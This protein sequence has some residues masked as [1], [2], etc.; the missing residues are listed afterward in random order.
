MSI[1]N[2]IARICYTRPKH[3][4]IVFIIIT[5]ISISLAV[6]IK[7]TLEFKDLMP[8]EW[9]SVDWGERIEEEFGS[10]DYAIIAI[11]ASDVTDPK[12]LAYVK[13][14]SAKLRKAKEIV[15]V[16]SVTD[17]QTTN[18]TS[19]LYLLPNK[20]LR[21]YREG[22]DAM[23]KQL[24]A[25]KQM[26]QDG[27]TAEE[28]AYIATIGDNI[29]TQILAK[30]KGDKE[31]YVSR[32]V[33]SDKSLLLIYAMPRKPPLDYAYHMKVANEIKEVVDSIERPEGV[34][35]GLGGMHVLMRDCC[36]IFFRDL[37]LMSGVALISILLILLIA[38]GTPSALLLLAA[39]LLMATSWALAL[40]Y[41]IYG[42][43]NWVTIMTIP[44]V[45]GVGIDYGIHIF[46]RYKEEIFRRGDKKKA[47]EMALGITG[48]PVF[49]AAVTTIVGFIALMVAQSTAIKQLGLAVAGG[50]ALTMLSMYFV[51]PSLLVLS[52]PK[53]WKMREEREK[54]RYPFEKRPG[55]VLII[56]IVVVILLG[57]FATDL[58]FE[59]DLMKMFPQDLESIKVYNLVGE[60]FGPVMD[61]AI[62]GVQRE[63][64]TSKKNLEDI[65]R[66]T[67]VLRKYT[68]VSSVSSITDFLTLNFEAKSAL[69]AEVGSAT[70]RAL[71]T[72]QEIL[73]SDLSQE[74]KLVN[75]QLAGI[76]VTMGSMVRN[77]YPV[78]LENL[79]PGLASKYLNEDNTMALIYI[80]PKKS[81]GDIE[82]LRNFIPELRNKVASEF[83]G[84]AGVTGMPALSYDMLRMV[85][86]DLK[87]VSIFAVVG[88]IIA[89]ILIFRS[90][91]AA[92][93]SL[94]P[95]GFGVIEM[96]GGMALLGYKMDIFTVTILS[97]I[98]G[99]GIDYG[100]HFMHRYREESAKGRADAVG[101]AW[102]GAGKAITIGAV[103]TIAAFISIALTKFTGVSVIGRIAAMGLFF[104]AINALLI[105][106]ALI[107]I[108]ERR[109][110]N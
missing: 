45:L 70:S 80:Q 38:F 79:P 59:S 39:P 87:R 98:L 56:G 36:E 6:K 76:F 46:H 73:I 29:S 20:T 110:G 44:L 19:N 33:S 13:I 63:N 78:T 49:I 1:L 85:D 62:V 60:K 40:V 12:V 11:E 90:I 91:S 41:L 10:T 9:E 68:E 57:A 95:L 52:K 34:K 5:I 89:L 69:V 58:K 64:I 23:A 83:K 32:F 37:P 43:L 47:L 84:R 93:L 50:V 65:R 18:R 88:I 106:P 81:T 100:V 103:T 31:E 107:I 28:S 105:L 82:Y 54:P 24:S 74:A 94:I 72:T 51:L 101:I 86:R 14:V 77:S 109:K 25:V 96:L 3:V 35:F 48:V 30:I 8:R 92:V 61:V 16:E 17:Y 71:N 108:L 27:Y 102:A 53:P 55:I 15:S 67:V 7:T 21:G 97:M 99:L 75:A 2:R 26:G 104:I 42:A 4:L 66:A 22:L